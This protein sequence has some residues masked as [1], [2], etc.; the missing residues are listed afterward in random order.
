MS[1]QRPRGPESKGDVGVRNLLA[2]GITSRRRNWR[3]PPASD[4]NAV[5]QLWR[6]RQTPRHPL[7]GGAP[8]SFVTASASPLKWRLSAPCVPYASTEVQR[9]LHVGHDVDSLRVLVARD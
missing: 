8:S 9:F 7:S 2:A 5:G 4:P 3:N 1:G 6:C